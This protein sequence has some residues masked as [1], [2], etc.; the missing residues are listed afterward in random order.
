M[1]KNEVIRTESYYCFEC[2]K[3]WFLTLKKKIKIKVTAFRIIFGDKSV[4]I[5]GGCWKLTN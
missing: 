4:Y 1:S 3:S 5:T 2:R